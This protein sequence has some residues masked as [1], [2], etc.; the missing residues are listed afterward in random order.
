MTERD[1]QPISE[2]FSLLASGGCIEA[3]PRRVNAA[4]FSFPDVDSVSTQCKRKIS[5]LLGLRKQMS[6]SSERHAE[7]REIRRDV[8][9][10]CVHIR[11]CSIA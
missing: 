2:H 8:M 9:L 1:G 6:K 7:R 5:P 11:S 3:M 4:S 10:K